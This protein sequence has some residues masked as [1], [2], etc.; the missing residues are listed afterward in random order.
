[1]LVDS[2]GARSGDGWGRAPAEMYHVWWYTS[3]HVADLGERR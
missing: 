1:M 2:V 3:G